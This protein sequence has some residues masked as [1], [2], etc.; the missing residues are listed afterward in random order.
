MKK[1]CVI[2]ALLLLLLL[3]CACS[4]QADNIDRPYPLK[5]TY[6]DSEVFAMSSTYE[7]FWKAGLKTE[8]LTADELDPRTM[9]TKLSYLN[10]GKNKEI[11]LQFAAEPAKLVV[12]RYSASDGFQQSE[13][14]EIEG[15]EL[16]APDDGGDYIY[17]VRAAWM[18]D[19]GV[20]CW[21]S[22][23]YNFRFLPEGQSNNSISTPVGDTDTGD[24]DLSGVLA[25]DAS[26]ILGVEFINNLE[27]TSKT[28]RSQENKAAILQFLNSNLTTKFEEIA[29]ASPQA[30]YALRVV[31]MG[32]SQLSIGYGSDDS[33]SWLI[34]GGKTYE[35]DGMDLS[36]LW[37]GLVAGTI[38]LEAAASGKNYLNMSE[39]FPGADWGSDF[40]YG[41]LTALDTVAAYDEM[42]WIDDAEQPN[43]Y[44]LEN[45]WPNQT[46]TVAPDC[47][48]WILEEHH[49]PYCQVTAEALLQWAEDA[50]FDVLFRIYTKDNQIIAICE[51]YQP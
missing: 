37:D 45:G 40:V 13:Y 36:M 4:K 1:R 35:A 2:L 20:D 39:E 14:I 51:Q 33:D 47:Q 9:L 38:S 42:R 49:S 50:E 22:C 7:W 19:R 30:D 21:G 6:G 28:C 5:V 34:L 27:G 16:P 12:E 32:G 23:T 29:V 43:G 31:T 46:G 10:A 17:T 15:T 25:L 41:Y 18:E 24:L 44:R 3:L 8:T 26:Q 48:F 11:E